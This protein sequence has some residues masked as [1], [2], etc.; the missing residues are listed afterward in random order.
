MREKYWFYSENNVKH[1]QGTNAGVKSFF[2]RMN[3]RIH[4]RDT[5]SHYTSIPDSSGHP[6]IAERPRSFKVLLFHYQFS[7]D[8]F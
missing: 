3:T 5:Q 2:R 4:L 8:L 1:I 6:D 7:I